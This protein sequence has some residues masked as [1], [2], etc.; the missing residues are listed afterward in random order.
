MSVGRVSTLLGV[1]VG[2][3]SL[4]GAVAAVDSRYAKQVYVEKIEQRLDQKIWSDRYYQIQQRIWQLQ[5]RYPIPQ[6]MPQSV[7]EELRKL[8]FL[9]EQIERK[10]RIPA[11]Q[12]GT[13]E[14][15]VAHAKATAGAPV[16]PKRIKVSENYSMGV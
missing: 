7:K 4:I 1:L 2:L 5:D 13:I 6:N 3:C 8:K 16:P 14:L 10:L 15:A 12:L 11:D 9:K